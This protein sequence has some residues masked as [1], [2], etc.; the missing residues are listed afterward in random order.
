[1][2]NFFKI[3]SVESKFDTLEIFYREFIS[4]KFLDAKPENI[5]HKFTVLN[6][7]PSFI[8]IWLKSTK[9]FIRMSLRMIR[10]I[11][12]SK[13]M[14]LKAWKT[15]KTAANNHAYNLK[16]EETFLFQITTKQNSEN[17]AHELYDDLIKEDISA[18]EKRKD[19]GKDKRENILNILR[20]LESVFTGAYLHYDNA[21][22]S[23]SEPES[24][25]KFE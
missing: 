23:E 8:M 25:S 3:S 2:I 10:V 1:M 18:L 6:D 17:K 15:A 14:I 20:N 24:E 21:S 22:K 13:N 19:I 4:L 9:K 12:G 16:S 7:A 11:I 5:N